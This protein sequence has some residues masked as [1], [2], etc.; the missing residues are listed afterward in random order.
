YAPLSNRTAPAARIMS[1]ATWDLHAPNHHESHGIFFPLHPLNAFL[2]V[3]Y[4]KRHFHCNVTLSAS[5]SMLL[6]EQMAK[7]LKNN[8]NTALHAATAGTGSTDTDPE[9]RLSCSEF[10]FEDESRFAKLHPETFF[11]ASYIDKP[12]C[13]RWSRSLLEE[14]QCWLHTGHSSAFTA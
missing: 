6:W 12:A 2:N 9:S 8:T 4:P 3:P 7:A 11:G 10:S 5:Q 14:L 13:Q 1:P